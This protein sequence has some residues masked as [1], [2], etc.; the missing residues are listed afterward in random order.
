MVLC[1]PNRQNGE[2]SSQSQ[3]RSVQPKTISQLWK[4]VSPFDE[5]PTSS[6]NRG[7]DDKS[8]SICA[9]ETFKHLTLLESQILRQSVPASQPPFTISPKCPYNTTTTRSHEIRRGISSQKNKLSGQ[10][11]DVHQVPISVQVPTRGMFDL[12]DRSASFIS[13]LS[14]DDVCSEV[15]FDM[16]ERDKKLCNDVVESPTFQNANYL[17]SWNVGSTRDAT[18]LKTTLFRKDELDPDAFIWPSDEESTP[19]KHFRQVYSHDG[20]PDH[21][22]KL[23]GSHPSAALIFPTKTTAWTSSNSVTAFTATTHPTTSRDDRDDDDPALCVEMRPTA[24]QQD[25]HNDEHISWTYE[26][27]HS[28]RTKSTESTSSWKVGCTALNLAC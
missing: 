1:R 21:F 4:T 23:G 9:D 6:S 5:Y 11:M 24:S 18:R 12:H 3:F 15:S 2:F 22:Q 17:P 7:T 19:T 14:N 25:L 8:S 10:I 16:M 26:E 20:I 28:S 13:N 27:L